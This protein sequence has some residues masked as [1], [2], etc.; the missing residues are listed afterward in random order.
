MYADLLYGTISLR[1]QYIE[2]PFCGCREVLLFQLAFPN[3]N[4]RPSTILETLRCFYIPLDVPLTLF[5]P[6][7]GMVGWSRISA[8]MPMPE[9]TIDKDGDPFIKKDEIRMAFY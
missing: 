4:N 3:A 6:I 5:L 8:V 9:T 2:N 1:I 7:L